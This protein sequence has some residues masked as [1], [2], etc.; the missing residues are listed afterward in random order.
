MDAGDLQRA[1]QGADIDLTA[2][3]RHL[4]GPGFLGRSIEHRP[5]V[6]PSRHVVERLPDLRDVE[7]Q[8]QVLV[9][10]SAD[11]DR[12]HGS[13]PEAFGL[14]VAV[15]LAC[16]GRRSEDQV[17]SGGPELIR[18]E[19]M[20]ERLS[21]PAGCL[22]G[23]QRDQERGRWPK[24]GTFRGRVDGEYRHTDRRDRG[25]RSQRV[26]ASIHRGAPGACVGD[27]IACPSGPQ[28]HVIVLTLHR[29]RP[30]PVIRLQ[31]QRDPVQRG[32]RRPRVDRHDG[33]RR[34]GVREA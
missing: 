25:T 9:R 31:R 17:S 13:G 10:A 15:L 5:T 28:Q 18:D 2:A 11:H 1:H 4:A 27:D 7:R 12:E 6:R 19:V 22:H 23:L 33:H 20:I 26:H 8:A 32:L 24:Q 3:E 21:G 29:A 14:F 16:L 34:L 30:N